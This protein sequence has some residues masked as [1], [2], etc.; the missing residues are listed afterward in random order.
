MA[1]RGIVV[2]QLCPGPVA[3]EFESVAQALLE[4]PRFVEI[5]VE[6]CVTSA[7]RGFEKNK[8]IIMP[9]FWINLTMALGALTPRWLLRLVYRPV[10]SRMRQLSA[11]AAATATT[12]ATK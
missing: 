9:G 6:H 5:S 11:R 4:P 7:L 1:G 8:A 10:A 2:S 3:T 12:P